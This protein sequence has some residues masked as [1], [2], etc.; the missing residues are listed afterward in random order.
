VH[1]GDGVVFSVV[2]DPLEPRACTADLTGAAA[3]VVAIERSSLP[4]ERFTLQ[5][6]EASVTCADCGFTE[7]IEVELP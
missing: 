2:S 7:Q 1:I 6:R 3:F 4:A 5:L